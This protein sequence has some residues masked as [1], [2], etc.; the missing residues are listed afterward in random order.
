MSLASHLND[1]LKKILLK[2][3]DKAPYLFDAQTICNKLMEDLQKADSDFRKAF[4]GL[5]LSGKSFA[6]TVFL[7]YFG[8]IMSILQFRKLLGP[9]ETED[10]R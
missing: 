5:S 1:I 6:Q 4:N 3:D 7:F 2:D 10:A 8:V 9:F